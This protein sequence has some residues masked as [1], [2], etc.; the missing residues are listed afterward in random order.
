MLKK[1]KQQGLM[2]GLMLSHSAAVYPSQKSGPVTFSVSYVE[3]TKQVIES[4]TRDQIPSWEYSKAKRYVVE[5][6]RERIS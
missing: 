2:T 6:V 1:F 3:E 5:Q 4:W